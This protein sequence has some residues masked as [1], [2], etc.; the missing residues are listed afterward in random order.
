MRGFR[1]RHDLT[2]TPACSLDALGFSLRIP[3]HD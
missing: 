2:E 1:N 3:D